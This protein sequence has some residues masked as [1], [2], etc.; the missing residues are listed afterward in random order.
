MADVSFAGR[1]GPGFGVGELLKRRGAIMRPVFGLGLAIA[2]LAGPA[3]AAVPG[4]ERPITNPNSIVS[5]PNLG[6]RPVPIADLFQTRSGA[7]AALSPDGK[8]V[9]FSANFTGRYNLWKT[10]SSGEPATQLTKSD[11]RQ[12]SPRF[13]PDGRFIAYQSDVGGNEEYDIYLVPVAGGAPVDITN[14]PNV[15]EQNPIFT[16]DGGTIAVTRKPK[17][18]SQSDIWVIDTQTHAARALTHEADP[19]QQWSPV[20]FTADGRYLIANR[21]DVNQIGNSAWKID[22][23]TG[24]AQKITPGDDKHVVYA[25][26]LSPDGSLLAISANLT[27]AQQQAGVLDLR[28]GKIRWL[29]PSPWEQS[30]E[31]FS[32]DGRSV[33]YTVNDDGRASLNLYDLATGKSRALSFPPGL[34]GAQG[35]HPFTPDGRGVLLSHQSANTPLDYWIAPTA[36]GETAHKVS[37]FAAAELNSSRLPSSAI[38]HYAS[39]DGTVI[40]AV[41]LVPFNL[42]RDARAP[43]IVLPHGGPTGQTVDSFNR[44]AT[45]LASRGYIVIEPNVR[46]STG[47]GKPFQDANIKDLGGADLT[48]EVYAAKFLIATGYV[49]P[50]KIGITGGSYGGFMTLMAIGKTPDVWAAAVEQYGIINWYAMLQHEDPLLQ[51][52][53]RGLIGDPVKDKAVYDATSP[54]TYI[55]NV[56]APL[57]VL[58]G[59]NDIRVPK[60]QAEEVVATLKASG[61]VVEA[62]YYPQEGHGFAKRENQ[63][64]ALERTVAWFDKYLK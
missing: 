34:D 61:H 35:V 59:E 29:A 16:P 23:A 62:H 6:A 2:V 42:T 22:V 8:T 21:G 4:P 12:Y 53:E 26:D 60:G 28:T 25:A 13:S 1:L 24:K 38:V 10:T 58:Q 7:G 39:Q 9:V 40:S 30:S 47:Y 18:A 31:A 37:N 63:I 44:T 45:A 33:L 49:D 50:K 19:I 43:A 32:P 48:D 57:L 46:G 54:M 17:S 20:V 3:S 41:M 51:Q 56:R 36:P 14:T 27:S 55:K 64:D 5:A 11:D 15:S 52:Y